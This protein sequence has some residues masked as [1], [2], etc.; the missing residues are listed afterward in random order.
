MYTSINTFCVWRGGRQKEIKHT[1]AQGLEDFPAISHPHSSLHLFASCL[2]TGD[3]EEGAR[4]ASN[5]TSLR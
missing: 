2:N 3:L 1:F 4:L 5:S